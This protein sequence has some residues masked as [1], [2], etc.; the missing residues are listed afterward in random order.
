[1]QGCTPKLVTLIRDLHA[2]HSAV[3]HSEVDSAPVDTSVV[4]EQGCVLAPPLFNVCLD[5]VIGQLLP[6][7][8]RLGGHHLL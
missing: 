6:Q 1:M 4:F 3:I 7:L 2:H 5:S 8:Q